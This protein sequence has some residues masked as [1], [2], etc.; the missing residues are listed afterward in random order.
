MNNTPRFAEYN[1][2][3]QHAIR[4]A[5]F[6]I[7][8][9]SAKTAEQFELKVFQWLSQ[10]LFPSIDEMLSKHCAANTVISIDKLNIDIG[11]VEE[12]KLYPV[13]RDRII[14]SVY[15]AVFERTRPENNELRQPSF[16]LPTSRPKALTQKLI[17]YRWNQAWNFIVSGQLRW[18]QQVKAQLSETGLI[19]LLLDN[20]KRI[21]SALNHAQNRDILCLRLALQL[22]PVALAELL[23]KLNTVNR[24]TLILVL[25]QRP[26]DIN[27]S[28]GKILSKHWQDLLDKALTQRSLSELLPH[29]E[30]L[31][32]VYGS[33]LLKVIYK[34]SKEAHLPLLLV[35]SLND[36]ERL[37]LLNQLEPTEYPFLKQL[38]NCPQLW[39]GKSVT[40]PLTTSHLGTVSTSVTVKQHLWLFTFH[41]VLVERGSRFNKQQYMTSL[42]VRMA[43]LSNGDLSVL[44]NDLQVSLNAVPADSALR[45]QM[46]ELL[47]VIHSQVSQQNPSTAPAI[48]K[49]SNDVFWMVHQFV[50][51][52]ANHTTII[53]LEKVL[54]D[55]ALLQ[56]FEWY[57]ATTPMLRQRLWEQLSHTSLR[58]LIK[59]LSN[60]P[61]DF[62][63]VTQHKK[64]KQGL[65]VE[66]DQLAIKYYAKGNPSIS[67][68]PL[69]SL[70]LVLQHGDEQS[71]LQ[72]LPKY[73]SPLRNALL[74]IGQLASVRQHWAEHYSDSTLFHFTES[75]EPRALKT[76]QLVM[77]Q[78]THFG[79]AIHSKTTS[80]RL[81]NAAIRQSVWQFTLSYLILDRGSEFNRRSYLLALTH[82]MA[83][84]RNVHHDE[85]VQSIMTALKAQKDHPLF[86]SLSALL[87][88]VIDGHRS[89]PEHE[90]PTLISLNHVERNQVLYFVF[91]EPSI[92]V[93]VFVTLITADP[94]QWKRLIK[95][96]IPGIESQ[97]LSSSILKLSQ[98]NTVRK[99]W[100]QRFDTNTL[101]QLLTLAN[102]HLASKVNV[103]FDLSLLLFESLKHCTSSS[104]HQTHSTVIE[105]LWNW[106]FLSAPH[107]QAR[108]VSSEELAKWYIHELAEHH[109][110]NIN[111]LSTTILALSRRRDLA[112]SSTTQ[113]NLI[114]NI[115]RKLNANSE[116]E[117]S[118]LINDLQNS[119]KKLELVDGQITQLLAWISKPSSPDH[120]R[121]LNG[122]VDSIQRMIASLSPGKVSRVTPY[123]PVVSYLITNL[124]ISVQWLYQTLLSS[125]PPNDINDWVSLLMR[126]LTSARPNCSERHHLTQLHSLINLANPGLFSSTPQHLW[127]TATKTK[128]EAIATISHWLQRQEET[129]H[130]DEV[131]FAI[132]HHHTALWHQLSVDL[133]N[134]ESLLHWIRNL[135]GQLHIRFVG[136]KYSE[137]TPVIVE[138]YHSL[139]TWS[140]NNKQLI[141]AFW[142]LI[143]Q[144][145]LIKGFSGNYTD[146]LATILTDLMQNSLIARNLQ[147]NQPQEA[148][149][150]LSALFGLT[151]QS[152]LRLLIDDIVSRKSTLVD[153]KPEPPTKL[154]LSHPVV[155]RL[156]NA[157]EPFD[158]NTSSEPIVW[159]DPNQQEEKESE[160]ILVMNAGLVLASTYIPVLFQRLSLTSDKA[161]TAG[162]AQLQAMFCLQ[163]LTNGTNAAPEYL[164]MLNKLLCGIPLSTPIP[165]EMALPNGADKIIEGLLNAMIGHWSAIGNTTVE[166]LR[167]TFLQR[168]GHLTN[169]DK[170]WELNVI[171][172]TFDVLLDQLP[173]SF[174]TIKYPWMDKPLF[175]TWR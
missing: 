16:P 129:S 137:L 139:C 69:A 25:L 124:D 143:Y 135:N 104:L 79:D 48:Y 127:L 170:H 1:R 162:E 51:A 147:A 102:H 18:P 70:L 89:F 116:I 154:D 109:R 167:T 72:V 119:N 27:S 14:Q 9:D 144:R 149:T 10:E 92:P 96:D 174:Q 141:T 76:V 95:Q 42:L 60:Y 120:K 37:N 3:Q 34:H 91:D 145:C 12:A 71:L 55:P 172:G 6:E 114:V 131:A 47:S 30:K 140:G 166:G 153:I 163:Y 113:Q 32:T 133:L 19:E 22:P 86:D 24:C 61:S 157:I 146:L 78:R 68:P 4:N 67:S 20:P 105:H 54:K 73:Y 43:S 100:T 28:L 75:I 13:L 63:S 99:R 123:L 128:N 110:I 38:L 39:L 62:S 77:S 44:I 29:W 41:F 97:R 90:S 88:E 11:D 138:L 115:G 165:S 101:L 82:Q 126:K 50:N 136:G 173:W 107:W 83:S 117:L 98:M 132:S 94:V 23:P 74:W 57:F 111:N 45:Q 33:Q 84:R 159:K 152:P 58:N 158:H 56:Q 81:T 46:A 5:E 2:Q 169:Q 66:W 21:D 53:Q 59:V 148:L 15:Q 112:C 168:E 80:T 49:R 87:P 160:P 175:V 65:K 171:P 85:L 31:F 142:G 151:N 134:K 103:L 35:Q 36:D 155:Q 161:F 40:S 125:T 7:S 106:L 93:A 118:K 26:V 164:L 52:K 122:D 108:Q 64:N 8:F 121:W 156:N 17:D 130:P 150:E